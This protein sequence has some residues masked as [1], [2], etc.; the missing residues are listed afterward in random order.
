ML[1]R[2]GFV[3]THVRHGGQILARCYAAWDASCVWM[4]TG[5]V[6][7]IS[8]FGSGLLDAPNINELGR[9]HYARLD[10]Y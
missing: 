10:R 5:L 6:R 1:C 4:S 9:L 7:S 2:S 8:E 3:L